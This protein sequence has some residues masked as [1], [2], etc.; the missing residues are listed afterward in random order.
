MIPEIKKRVLAV[1]EMRLESKAPSTVL[2]ASY[3]HKFIQIQNEPETALIV[4]S[5]SSES[6]YYIPIG[7]V[8][9]STV[10]NNSCYVIYNSPLY[11]FSVLSSRFHVN[12]VH[13]VAGKLETRI[14]YSSALCYNIFPFPNISNQR[15]EELTQSALNNR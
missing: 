10:V 5:V 14:R 12:W 7:F 2:A 3:S 6:R 15:K 13:A 1:K 11:I 4:P 9:K 8:D